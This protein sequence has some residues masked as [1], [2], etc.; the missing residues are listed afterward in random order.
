MSRNRYLIIKRVCDIFLSLILITILFFPMLMISVLVKITS[1]GPVIFWSDRI[2]KN[3]V[4]FK[5]P[6]F[7]SM[8]LKTP[9]IATHL[10]KNPEQYL[11]PIGGFIRK[12]SLDELPQLFS[13][14]IGQMSFVGPRPALHSQ[15]DL[16]SLR[17]KFYIDTIKP[18]IT[19]L[20]QINGRD[21]ISIEKKV[22]FDKLYL[23]TMSN[24][25]DLKII[26]QTV[27]S[28]TKCKQVSH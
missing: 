12:T 15:T 24:K 11:S 10:L 8:V 5:M 6:K 23:E 4:I 3:G 1:S 27:L 9:D 17:K 26:W 13:I 2:G 16:E 28:V 22:E 20:A 25:V 7:R 19:G 21:M 18:G 14:L